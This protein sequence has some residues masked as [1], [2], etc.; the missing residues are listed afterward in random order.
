MEDAQ[1][2][3]DAQKLTYPIA[4]GLSGSTLG[5]SLGLYYHPKGF[6]HATGFI[7]KPDGTVCVAVYGTGAI[8][9][10]SA[11]DTLMVIDFYQARDKP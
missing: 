1:K 10:L 9:R 3:V 6:I 8:G 7:I 2:T 4:Y 11:K 5:E